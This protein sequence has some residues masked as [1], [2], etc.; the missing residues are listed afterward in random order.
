[1]VNVSPSAFLLLTA[2]TLCSSC[3]PWSSL[4]TVMSQR[5]DSGSHLKGRDVGRV[6]DCSLHCLAWVTLLVL[7]CLL[8]KG[9]VSGGIGSSGL[10]LLKSVEAIKDNETM[11]ACVS[12]APG[13]PPVPAGGPPASFLSEFRGVQYSLS[14]GRLPDT[15][16]LCCPFP[17]SCPMASP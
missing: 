17:T 14:L 7:L 1:M 4:P 11:V 10:R 8:P 15:E 6:A 9:V 16:E 12:R 2:A 13:L 5:A 3:R